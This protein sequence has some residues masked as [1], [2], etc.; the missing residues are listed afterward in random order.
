MIE[1][2]KSKRWILIS[3]KGGTG[4]TVLACTI[5]LQMAKIGEKTLVVSVDPAHS[6]SDALKMEIGPEIK[7]VEGVTQLH[8]L[9]FTPAEMYR[10]D[11]TMLETALGKYKQE[12]EGMEGLFS[13]SPEEMLGTLTDV[14]SLPLEY[15]EGLAFI[16]LF[17]SLQES[18][19]DKIIFDT[20]PTGHTLKLLELPDALDSM[21]GKIIRFRLKISSFWNKFKGL[22]GVKAENPQEKMLD[23]LERLKDTIIRLQNVLR[24]EETTEFITVTLPMVMSILESLRLVGTLDGYEIPHHFLVVNKLRVYE[25]DCT[26]CKNLSKIHEKNLHQIQREFD[27]L[28]IRCVPYFSEEVRGVDKLERFYEFLEGTTPENVE[29]WLKEGE[30]IE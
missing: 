8:A 13:L 5:A 1:E 21:L 23:A 10:M 3:G 25:G 30:D 22:F 11:E 4:K 14:V 29:S 17:D 18:E 19:F 26:F 28:K 7:E 27:D 16:K 9:E 15:T 20:A 6:L 24:N 12:F 2:L